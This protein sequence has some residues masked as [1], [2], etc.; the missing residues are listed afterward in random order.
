ML[1]RYSSLALRAI[2][3]IYVMA[4]LFEDPATM[5]HN[6]QFCQACK[7]ARY[8]SPR[9]QKLHWRAGHKHICPKIQKNFDI[10]EL[11]KIKQVFYG[12]ITPETF[13]SWRQMLSNSPSDPIAVA[14]AMGDGYQ[15]YIVAPDEN[16]AERI[17]H[18]MQ[19]ERWRPLWPAD[20]DDM[21]ERRAHIDEEDAIAI[22]AASLGET[23]VRDICSEWFRSR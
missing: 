16:M 17:A 14:Q 5:D 3:H 20:V 21:E 2:F 1:Y 7:F 12:W 10:A 4:N 9:C 18:E 15:H 13:V 19:V 23:E 6:M 8:C 22:A 11:R